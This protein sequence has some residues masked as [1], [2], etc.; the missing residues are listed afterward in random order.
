MAGALLSIFTCPDLALNIDNMFQPMTEYQRTGIQEARNFKKLRRVRINVS[1]SRQE[2][3]WCWGG[4]CRWCTIKA[5]LTNGCKQAAGFISCLVCTK[6]A[7]FKINLGM[8]HCGSLAKVY[9][10]GTHGVAVM[11]KKSRVNSESVRTVCVSTQ[12]SLQKGPPF[13]STKTQSVNAA[14]LRVFACKPAKLTLRGG[15]LLAWLPF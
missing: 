14:N 11:S 15:L 6:N 4:A 5:Y 12:P 2:S 10:E 8:R 3:E 7:T 9:C 1:K 13:S